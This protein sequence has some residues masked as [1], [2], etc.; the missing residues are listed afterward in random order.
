[1]KVLL[2]LSVVAALLSGTDAARGRP[3]LNGKTF[4]AD[5]GQLLR[6]PFTSTE[7]AGPASQSEVYNIRTLGMNALHLY[8]EVFGSNT[9]GYAAAKVDKIVQ[10]T[11]DAGLYLIMTIGN[12]ANNGKYNL[13]YAVGFWNFYSKRY[14]S[15][16]H[17][18]FEIQN[19]P[20]AWGPPYNSPSANPPGA[21]NLQVQSYKAIRANAPNTPVLFFSYSVLYNNGAAAVADIQELN[22]QLFGNANAKWSNEAVA[23]H[24]YAGINPT[25]QSMTTILN[26]GYP[27]LQTEFAGGNPVDVNFIKMMES[28]G[29]SWLVFD[30]I[31]SAD[32]S[33]SIYPANTYTN[34]VKN[35]GL[36][37]SADFS[38][39]PCG[40][41]PV[42]PGGGGG[43]TTTTTTV[44]TS[45]TPGNGGGNGGSCSAKYGQ[46][47]GQG[48]SGPKCCQ[49]GSTCQVSNP[50]Y[51]QC[52]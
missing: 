45:P 33:S 17:V 4:V 40:R 2:L 9:P 29:I 37:W 43:P 49:A 38:T 51:S 41:T 12:G 11:A 30:G 25:Q 52:V 19:E 26:A 36:C 27:M 23:F 5:N 16:T 31:T 8:A 7:W 3:R 10:Y 13:N 1:M 42:G 6:G 20:V 46:C 24:G 47:G 39:F 21:I 32:V 18:L 28:N 48:W 35:A 22:R 50:Y 15:Q 44:R 34:P 14:A